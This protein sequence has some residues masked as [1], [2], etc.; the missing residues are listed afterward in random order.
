MCIIGARASA[1]GRTGKSSTKCPKHC[2]PNGSCPGENKG[3]RKWYLRLGINGAGKNAIWS[4][5]YQM[6][7]E[8]LKSGVNFPTALTSQMT[9]WSTRLRSIDCIAYSIP[10]FETSK[11]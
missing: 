2:E 4:A 3:Q 9:E 1:F 10:S 6:S 8:Y 7:T 11:P 5:R